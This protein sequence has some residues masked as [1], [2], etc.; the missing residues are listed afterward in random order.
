MSGV[1]V[2]AFLSACASTPQSNYLIS[3]PPETIKPYAELHQVP[4]FPQTKYQC[5]PASLATV[6]NYHGI[7]IL[8]EDLAEKVY[9]PKRKGSL[10]IEMI[11]TARS[12]GMLAY[13]LEP[14]LSVLLEEINAGNPVLVFQNL[15]FSFWPQWHY[16]VIVGYDLHKA[17]LILRSG[18]SKNLAVSFSKFERTWERADYWAYVLIPAGTTP[19][20]ANPNEY[21]LFSH[22]LEKTA[23]IDHALPA[24]QQAAKKWPDNSLVLMTLGNAEYAAKNYEAAI[25]A[26]MRELELRPQN[27]L[28]WNNLSYALVANQC[29]E[30]A[31]KAVNCAVHLLPDD[32]NFQ[33]SLQEIKQIPSGSK[34]YCEDVRCTVD[35]KD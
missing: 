29:R 27:A 6:L 15:R 8:P 24:F 30:Q 28:A 9:I 13:K 19:V 26:F 35:W 31:L 11:A 17:E 3:S 34:G 4:F 18:R 7:D 21:I 10:Q 12:Q 1:F 22:E 32:K 33:Q 23:G 20:T 14:R 5:G 25:V 2:L 16:A